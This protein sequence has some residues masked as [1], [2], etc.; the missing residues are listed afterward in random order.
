M[1]GV[2]FDTVCKSR[3]SPN[4]NRCAGNLKK[5]WRRLAVVLKKSNFEIFCRTKMTFVAMPLSDRISKLYCR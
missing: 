1:G 2:C 3:K 4:Q 5:Q